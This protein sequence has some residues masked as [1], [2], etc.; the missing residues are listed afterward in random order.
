MKDSETL[1]TVQEIIETLANGVNYFT[2]EEAGED[3]IVND[4]RIVR[5]LFTANEVL[6]EAIG[7]Q[8]PKRERQYPKPIFVYDE[9]I[10]KNVKISSRPISL[11][12]IVRNILVAYNFECRLTYY[13]VAEILYREGILEYNEDGS[14]RYK[15]NENAKR[16]GVWSQY[17][18]R[19]H[20][21]RLQTFY[22]E[23]GQ[24]FVLEI[25]KKHASCV[26]ESNLCEEQSDEE[27]DL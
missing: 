15:A 10:I 12:E 24:R 5:A 19:R 18:Y 11:S 13:M 8:K 4:V 14:P 21:E 27:Q 25:L 2:G 26:E 23:N 16:Y 20:G 6:N 1:K 9:E 22:D 3:D 17:V 7:K